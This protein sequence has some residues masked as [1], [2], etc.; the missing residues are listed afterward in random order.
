MDRNTEKAMPPHFQVVKLSPNVAICVFIDL[1]S[2]LPLHVIA[3]VW[4]KRRNAGGVLGFLLESVPKNIS[5]S[6]DGR[7]GAVGGMME[8]VCFARLRQISRRE[9]GGE[10]EGVYGVEGGGLCL[11]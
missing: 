7:Y 1:L 4:G 9:E 5:M 11:I 3:V 6:L 2:L 10:V 8:V